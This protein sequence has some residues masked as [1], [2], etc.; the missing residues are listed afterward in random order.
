MLAQFVHLVEGQ[1]PVRDAWVPSGSSFFHD[2]LHLCGKPTKY[3]SEGL[4]GVLC[5][6]PGRYIDI[7]ISHTFLSPILKTESHVAQVDLK[8]TIQR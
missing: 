4:F 1:G 8:L 7:H 2:T 3:I 5:S 6:A